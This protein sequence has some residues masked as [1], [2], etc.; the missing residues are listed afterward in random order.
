MNI[1]NGEINIMDNNVLKNINDGIYD[2]KKICIIIKNIEYCYN[3]KKQIIWIIKNK[4]IKSI[5]ISYNKY[6]KLT[7]ELLKHNN[8]HIFEKLWNNKIDIIIKNILKNFEIELNDN[9]IK[10]LINKS[11]N[12]INK[13]KQI[14]NCYNIIKDKY[15]FVQYNN[16]LAYTYYNNELLFSTKYILSNKINDDDDI[17]DNDIDNDNENEVENVNNVDW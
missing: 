17:I 7:N 2:N 1:Q 10:L 9:E 14:C 11:E 16:L 15:T 12:N 3:E 6:W 8:Y 4:K 5:C 13:I